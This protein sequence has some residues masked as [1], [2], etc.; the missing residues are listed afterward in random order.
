MRKAVTGETHR[1]DWVAPGPLTTAPSANFKEEGQ[2]SIIYLTQTRADIS[3][4]AIAA[5]RRTLTVA[6][7]ASGLQADQ[8]RAFL[9]TAGD[10][11][12]PVVLTRLV[13]TTAILAEPLPREIDLGTN[14]TLTFALWY[15]TVPSWVTATSATYA[16]EV[17][18]SIDRGQGAETRVDRDL[19]KVTPRPFSTGLDHEALV[20]MFPQLADMI[21]RRQSDLEP[22][23]SAALDEVV[24]ALRDHLKDVELTEDEVFNGHAFKNAHAY[25]TAARVYESALQLDTASAMRERYQEMLKLALRLVAIDKDGDGIVDEGDLDNAQT[26]GSARD[27]RASWSTYTR[28]A[29]DTFFTPS[30]GMRH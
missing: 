14:A 6:S 18:Y 16:M 2:T 8:A 17:I 21:P 22:Q 3:V 20:G 4:S 7:Q 13:G 15:G 26:G 11:I 29:H 10:S 1:L 27:L 25:A 23:I 24:L 30:R 19:F 9:I 12:Y 28:N 5:D